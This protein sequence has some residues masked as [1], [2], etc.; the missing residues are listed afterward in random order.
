MSSTFEIM[1][2]AAEPHDG[3][4]S[5]ASSSCCSGFQSAYPSA[6]GFGIALL[7]GTDVSFS[8]RGLAM[9]SRT[10]SARDTPESFSRTA[11]SK[12]VLRLL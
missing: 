3:L 12:V 11:P 10:Y 1:S 4:Q 9:R 2:P 5:V 8:P 7:V 6:W